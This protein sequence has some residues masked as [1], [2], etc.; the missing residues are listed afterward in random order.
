MTKSVPTNK[1]LYNKVKTE[2][3]RNFKVWP[4]AYGSGWLVKEYKRR[5]GKYKLEKSHKHKSKSRCKSRRKSRKSPKRKSK[6]K[7]RKSVKRSAFSNSGW[8]IVTKDGCPYC[9]K[10][11]S[12]LS[13]KGINY[14]VE[15]ANNS[16]KVQIYK[17][18]DIITNNYRYFPMIFHNGK[19]IGGYTE[20][21]K[22]NF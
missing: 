18:V 15:V 10:A 7:R 16:N 4:S 14:K 22:Y 21:E 8:Y 5:G 20:L 3:K 12:L 13:Q 11:K 19:F 17:K 6:S 2:A 9:D 1:L